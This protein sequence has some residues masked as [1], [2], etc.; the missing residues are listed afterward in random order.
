MPAG[1]DRQ[2]LPPQPSSK[3]DP[4]CRRHGVSYADGAV[5][6]GG[7]RVWLSFYIILKPSGSKNLSR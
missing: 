1:Q 5:T 4:L 3:A 2:A 6:H 7:C